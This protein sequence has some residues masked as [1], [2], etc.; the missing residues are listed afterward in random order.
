MEAKK[1]IVYLL[2]I[3]T[4]FLILLNIILGL[5]E[6]DY[7]P[8]NT[9]EDIPRI[10]IEE[11]FIS[12]LKN[13]KIKDNWIKK[14]KINDKDL[15]SVNYKYEIV[16]P[17]DIPIPMILK[18]LNE[19]FKYGNAIITSIEK[20]N[21]G[22]AN[23]KIKTDNYIKLVAN[24]NYKK[25]I[26]RERSAIAF[27]LK[28]V[29]NLSESELEKLLST[30]IKFATLLP[31]QTES[32]FIAEKILVSKRTY[33]IYLDDDSD[34]IKFEIDEDLNVKTMKKNIKSIISSFNSPHYYFTSKEGTGF[35]NIFINY[36][37]EEFK[38]RGRIVLN[39]KSFI[40][41]K[42][43]DEKDLNS[44]LKFHLNKIGPGNSK[45]FFIDIN[46]WESIQ[47]SI[48]SYIKKGNRI[49]SPSQLL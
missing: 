39:S 22:S 23:L 2:V 42:G 28:N 8:E 26:T 24:F 29:E 31:L 25:E 34:N 11:D 4:I 35:S 1:K 18:E 19:K 5:F 30:P 47:K 9:G 38:K 45:V 32:I 33:Y 44:L 48:N 17:T 36:L 15:D 43:E 14:K 41:L 40:T 10:K 6:S 3:F 37:K 49:K 13:F 21:F 27:I 20:N 12:V 7:I 46:D 16:I